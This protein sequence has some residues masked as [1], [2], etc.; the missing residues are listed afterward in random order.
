M[1]KNIPLVLGL[2]LV[3][4]GFP[5]FAEKTRK[6]G[7]SV[8]AGAFMTN[9]KERFSAP[10]GM[11]GELSTL[12]GYLRVRPLLSL[13]KSFY[14]EP[15]LGTAL[16]WRSGADGSAKAFSTHFELML[17]KEIKKFRVRL[18]PGLFWGLHLSSSEEVGLNNGMGE[19]T[20]YTPGRSTNVF[21]ITLNAGLGVWLWEK[22]SLNLDVFTL[23][24]F[25]STRRRFNGALTLGIK[26]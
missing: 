19:S 5:L 7:V 24:P 26:L 23:Q 15:A 2:L 14:F 25:S 20:F 4:Y 18:G 9:I 10:S 12:T 16:P 8:D 3:L 17:A 13:G 21:L 11:G 22:L 1:K 6:S